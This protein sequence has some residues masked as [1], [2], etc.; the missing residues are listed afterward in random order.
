MHYVYII[1]SNKLSKNYVGSTSDLRSRIDQHKSGYSK[2]TSQVDD[3][4]LVYYE[5]FLSKTA[6]L[7]EE[8]F[9]KSG[10]GRER[11]KYLLSE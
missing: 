5:A 2:Y 3:W 6:A 10:K 11:T 4:Q 7:K 8:K 9:L 1:H